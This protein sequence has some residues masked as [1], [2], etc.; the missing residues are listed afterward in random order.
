MKLHIVPAHAG[1]TWV[2]LGMRTFFKQPLAMSG[3]FFTFIIFMSVTSLL[4]VV[5]G[6]LAL[7]LVPGITLGLMAATLEATRGKFPLPTVLLSA[8]RAGRQR[9]NAMLVLGALYALGFVL[10]VALTAVVDGGEFAKLYLVGGKLSDE[11]VQQP[12]FQLAMWVALGLYAPLSMLFWHAPALVHWHGI[13]PVQ[14][15]FY[16]GVACVK[17]FWALT[18]YGVVWLLVFMA[19]GVAVSLLMVLIGQPETAPAVMLPAALTMASMFF[20]SLYFTFRDSFET[21]EPAEPAGSEPV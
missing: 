1:L 20:T 10:I 5:G 13:P 17:N 2:K 3:L 6:L 8:F 9:L 16:S 19:M 18:V 12:Q 11:V 21:D 4:P 7:A 15:L 14:S